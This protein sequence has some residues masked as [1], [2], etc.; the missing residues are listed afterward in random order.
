M[1]M[2]DFWHDLVWTAIRNTAVTLQAV[3]PSILAMLTLLAL[4]TLLGGAAGGVIRRFAR[5][6]NFDRR[7]SVWGLTGALARAGA[8]RRPSGV[9]GVLTFWRI[10]G[11]SA[12][13]AIGALA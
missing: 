8:T 11:G 3:I 1:S 6:L 10:F 5:A 4:G 7:S 12:L 9:I 13:L 2:T